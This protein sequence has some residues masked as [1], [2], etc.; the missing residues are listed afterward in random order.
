MSN[1]AYSG[2]ISFRLFWKFLQYFLELLESFSDIDTTTLH[3]WKVN[4]HR[5]FCHRFKWDN[6][7]LSLPKEF[8]IIRV[9]GNTWFPFHGFE[10]YISDVLTFFKFLIYYSYFSLF[11][12]FKWNG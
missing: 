1:L 6:F 5:I 10:G 3:A 9:S 8:V 4:E 7:N 11:I 2:I 12:L